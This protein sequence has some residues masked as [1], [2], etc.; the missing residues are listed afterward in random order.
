MSARF[1]A[2]G[3]L[4]SATVA[5]NGLGGTTFS[6][7]RIENVALQL[8]GDG[9]ANARIVF[10]I[11]WDNS[12]R[13]PLNYDAAWVFVKLRPSGELWRHARLSTD[14]ADHAV[15]VANGVPAI[16]EPTADGV[17]V[18]L[19]R[20]GNGFTSIDWDGVA[21]QLDLTASGIDAA[22]AIEAEVVGFEMVYVPEGPFL[23]GDGTNVDALLAAQFQAGASPRPYSV[24]SEAAITL[25]G[26]AEGSLGNRDRRMPP[27]T[28]QQY[29]DDFSAADT[30]A[31][32]AAFPKGFA[33]FYAMKYEITQGDYAR[34]LNLLDRGQ[35]AAR[36][37]GREAH[38]DEPHR[39]AIST[40]AP[41]RVAP[42]NRAANWLSWM[43]VAAFADWSGLRP[44]TE[45]EY[46]KAA[47][48]DRFPDPGEFAWGPEAPPAGKYN[49]QDA[50]TPDELVVNQEEGAN[51]AFDGTIGLSSTISGPLRVAAF[52]PLATSRLGF[53]GSHYRLTELSGNL[54]ELVVTTGRA[55][56]RRFS[57]RHGDGVLSAAGNA[58]G[59][60]V[61]LWPG[62]QRSARGSYEVVNADGTGRRGGSWTA[63]VRSLRV[64]DR[65]HVNK[66]ADRRDMSWGGR[67]VRGAR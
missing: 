60:E 54:A 3:L 5:C 33:P 6:D 19:Y 2:V 11:A 4:A 38:A 39:Y 50:D 48:G 43:D 7:V 34:F 14:G 8:P 65:E 36:N 58:A 55:D 17:G 61:E 46:E 21:L 24:E 28:R 59:Q 41:F 22:A 1:F 12:F 30:Q 29:R 52:L 57:G 13:D 35:Q 47:R 27:A 49:L 62:A 63:G 20:E 51:V 66:P 26:D 18:F 40:E 45:L 53:G 42:Y 44:M 15:A 31:L 64:S 56:G 32:P 16:I 67:L 37:P 9:V 23:A 25:G 10:D